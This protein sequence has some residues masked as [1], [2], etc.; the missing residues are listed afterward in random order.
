MGSNPTPSALE[1]GSHRRGWAFEP[2]VEPPVLRILGSPSAPLLRR[3]G[4]KSH[5][6]GHNGRG[7]G[8]SSS[9]GLRLRGISSPRHAFGPLR[10]AS[11]ANPIGSGGLQHR[12]VAL[13][14]TLRR[15]ASLLSGF[16]K[17]DGLRPSMFGRV[18]EWLKA[19]DWKSCGLT[20][21]WVRI[22]PRPLA[23]EARH[24]TAWASNP[25]WR[26]RRLRLPHLTFGAAGR[27]ASVANPTPWWWSPAG[28]WPSNPGG[29]GCEPAHPPGA[30]TL[31][32]R[33]VGP[34]I[35]CIAA[36]W[37]QLT[38]GAWLS[39]VERCVR[40]AEVP[41][42]NP[43]APILTAGWEVSVL[44]PIGPVSSGGVV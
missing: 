36:W 5:P 32:A 31:L 6:V 26:L 13:A 24:R 20:P 15:R 21:T 35:V 29:R 7:G 3:L 8:R 39:P 22:P 38:F 33:R 42:S 34:P 40:V 11:A 28:E 17:V 25:G 23:G 16:A 44:K 14:R 19:H 10:G 4:C 37:R 30:A 9:T 43:G 41:G 18:A 27:G 12:I 1:Q 2:R